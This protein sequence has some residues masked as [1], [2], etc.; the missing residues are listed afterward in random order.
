VCENRVLR[1][2]FGLFAKYNYNYQVREDEMGGACST[3]GR[4]EECIRILVGKLERKRLLGRPRHRWEDN[5]RM[6]LR[7]MGW[8]G[9]D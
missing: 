2:I 9:V 7:E 8:G 6:D 1:R 4:E 3:N 5:I